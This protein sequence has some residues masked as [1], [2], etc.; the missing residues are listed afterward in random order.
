MVVFTKFVAC[1]QT[2]TINLITIRNS[3][4]LRNRSLDIAFQFAKVLLYGLNVTDRA[5]GVNALLMPSFS[6]F[7]KQTLESWSL[8][9]ISPLYS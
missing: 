6:A 4:L 7:E 8:V 1:Q 2:E 9:A 5:R 3:L